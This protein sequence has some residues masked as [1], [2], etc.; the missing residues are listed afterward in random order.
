MADKIKKLKIE[1]EARWVF[2]HRNDDKLPI[3]FVRDELLKAD[4]IKTE[5]D[6]LTSLT[7]V[8]DS[9]VISCGELKGKIKSL[10]SAKYPDEDVVITFSEEDAAEESAEEEPKDDGRA[11]RNTD[12]LSKIEGAGEENKVEG[13]DIPAE[14][15]IRGLVGAYEFKALAEE[16]CDISEEI[17]RTQTY[18]VFL[19][20]SYLFS[21]GNGCGLTTYLELLAKLISERGLC[22]M[23]VNPVREERLPP[24]EESYSP[25]GSAVSA[26]SGGSEKNVKILCVDISEWMDHT[27][28]HNFKRFLRAVEKRCNQ[29]VVVFRVPFVDKAVLAKIKYS[30]SDLLS[31]RLVSFP[32]LSNG[33]IKECASAELKKYN[34]EIS[35]PAW[36]Y[37]FERISEEK[38]DGKFYG[39]NTIKKVV[40]ELI[41]LKHKTNAHRSSKSLKISV[42]DARALCLDADFND[43][44][45]EEQLNRL[46]GV[47]GIKRRVSEIIAQIE[48]SV[49]KGDVQR[50]CMHM[51]FVGNP[52]TGKTTVARIIGKI[53]KEKG[54]LRT[55]A[56]FEYA[57]R[58][59]CGRYVGETAPKTAAICRDAYGSVLFIDEAYSLYRGVAS[60]A[61]YGREAIDTL[62]AEM[63]NHRNDFVVIMAGYTDDMEQLMAGNIGLRSRM[64]YTIEFPN[65]TREQLYEIFLSMIKGKFA[66]DKGLPQAA[67]EFFLSLPEE[68]ITAKEFANA[69]Y[70]R[71][72]FE[73][74]WA[75]AAMRCQLSGARDVTLTCDDFA[76]ACADKEFAINTPKNGRI[77]F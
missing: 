21:I 6:S 41:Y 27:E 30:L 45:G 68:I 69:R 63:E 10:I 74:T 19:N 7:V 48:L 42:N 64:P 11:S 18:D 62:I 32:P 77:G 31:V 54:V 23:A 17:K 34:Y 39:V 55:G 40:R 71:N 75:K 52:G 3:S 9:A 16:L 44:S 38:G 73:R 46:V 56:F 1:L 57:G 22:K 33:E 58:D 51:R 26:L 35:N 60:S 28:N 20:Q 2:S 61:D 70:V 4:G 53:L 72:L 37:F 67:H 14:E 29:F 15:K 47:D 66:Y 8:Y 13:E 25:F 50:P 24:F 49:R 76:H 43:L 5:S 36:K 65:F 12:I 59:F